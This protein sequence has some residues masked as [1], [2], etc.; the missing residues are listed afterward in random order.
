MAAGFTRVAEVCRLIG[1]S[2]WAYNRWE[3]RT[4]RSH[5]ARLKHPDAEIDPERSGRRPRRQDPITHVD[6]VL[7]VNLLRLYRVAYE[8]ITDAIPDEAPQ[9]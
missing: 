3:G 9:A 6:Y 4:P 1:M 8:D 5:S 7:M 2:R